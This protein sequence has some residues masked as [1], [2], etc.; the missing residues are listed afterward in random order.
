M[1]SQGQ[2]ADTVRGSVLG[3]K[4]RLSELKSGVLY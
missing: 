4:A 1:S 3:T 2:R